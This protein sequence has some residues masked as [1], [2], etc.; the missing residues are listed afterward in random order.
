MR[1]MGILNIRV[2]SQ[3]PVD[4]ATVSNPQTYY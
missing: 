2:V 1:A 4:K 3:S